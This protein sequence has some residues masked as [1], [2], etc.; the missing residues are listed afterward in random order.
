MH[1]VRSPKGSADPFAL[2]RQANGMLEIILHSHLIINIEKLV[3]YVIDL[4]EAE[5]GA[6]RMIKKTKGRGDKQTIVEVP[7]FD[8]S[9]C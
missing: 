7:E 6:G 5:F 4:G 1:L 2:R 9:T 3:D 8:W